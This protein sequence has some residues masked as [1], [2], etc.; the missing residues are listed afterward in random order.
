MIYT[1]K[2][3]TSIKILPGRHCLPNRHCE[4]KGWGVPLSEAISLTKAITKILFQHH[5]GFINRNC[6]FK[7]RHCEPTG[8]PKRVSEAI[9]FRKSTLRLLHAFAISI[10]K[11]R[12]DVKQITL[13]LFTIFL[14]TLNILPA[15]AT[16][17][18]VKQDGTGDFQTIQEGITASEDGDTVL[19]YPGIYNE[20]V[21]LHNRDI[22]LASLFFTTQD[23]QYINQTIIDPD[24][25]GESALRMG[26]CPGGY[27]IV[28]G[29]TIQH[30][31]GSEHEGRGGGIDIYCEN[32]EVRNCIIQNNI[33]ESGGGICVDNS[34][35]VIKNC[36]VQNNTSMVGGGVLCR[37]NGTAFFSGTSIRYNVAKLGGGGIRCWYESFTVFDPENRCNIYLNYSSYGSDYLKWDESQAQVIYVDTFTVL[38]PDQHF[39]YS[40]DDYHYPVND[41]T[42]DIQHAKIEPVNNDLYVNPVTGSDDNDG[43]SPENPLKTIALA[44]HIIASDNLNPLNIYLSPGVYSSSTNNEKLPLNGRSH[45][46]L[47]GTH[48]DSTIISADSNSYFLHTYGLM[49]DFKF[50]NIS[51]ESNYNSSTSPLGGIRINLCNQVL[52][53][54]LIFRNCIADGWSAIYSGY[55]DNIKFSDISINS[56]IGNSCISIWNSFE[57]SKNF[58]IEN[59]IVDNYRP[60]P[61]PEDLDGGHVLNL[62]GKLSGPGLYS[63]SVKNI[64]ITDNVKT[65]DPLWGPGGTVAITS[66]KFVDVDIVNVTVGHNVVR[67]DMG[68][69]INATEGANVNI[70]NSIFY[71][72]SLYELSLGSFSGTDDPATV[73]VAYSDIEGGEEDVIN[74]YN[75]NTLN[76]LEGN[77]DADPLWDTTSATPYELPWDSPCIDAGVPI[78]EEGMA[79][80]YI[81]IENEKIVLYKHDGD[82]LHIPSTD[83]AGNP[84]IVNGRIDMGAYEFQD[85]GVRIRELFLQNITETKIDIWP[86]P[87]SYNAF[88]S[89][90]LQEKAH[91]EVYIYSS[92]GTLV[93]K[94]MDANV[95]KGS[96][97]LTW[98]GYNNAG[99]TVKPGSYIV[100]VYLNGVKAESMLVVK[101]K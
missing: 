93:K 34:S 26:N 62:G 77:I 18:T 7:Y 5:F 60:Y 3:K 79:L 82:T 85:T 35:A 57:P 21:L 66:H 65:V 48:P 29:F 74:W 50:E 75:Q 31:G 76:W 80:P 95:S 9:L 94:L 51:F 30:G 70:Y 14:F 99:E 2:V 56:C 13:S 46:S 32:C 22:I 101:K 49:E 68:T 69:A 86:N 42:I 43:L 28:D 10:A 38:N 64:Q 52:F 37:M 6:N 58:E 4:L 1:S 44:Y 88:I 67:N 17:I 97:R 36:M 84:R 90:S 73:N 11:V 25:N 8:W 53:S 71:G 98:E 87:F 54:R 72:D 61:D 92:T 45:V 55:N 19:V 100:S 78:Y 63:G 33:A 47:I 91:T 20:N 12:N 81:K 40:A 15:N 27:P 89:F 23:E 16:T 83:L 41:L 24:Y 39:I 59:L 96:F